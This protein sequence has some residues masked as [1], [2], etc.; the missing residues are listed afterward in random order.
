MANSSA[1]AELLLDPEVSDDSQHSLVDLL[2]GLGFLVECRRKRSHRSPDGLTWLVLA[3]L[4]L[5]AF[6]SGL[7]EQVA[8]DLY[9]KLEKLVRR[10]PAERDSS[11]AD[12]QVPL[13]LQDSE[14]DLRIVLEADLPAEAYRQLVGL[15]LNAYRVGPLHYDRS[16]GEWRSELDEAAG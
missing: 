3:A 4:P 13:V 12:N 8:D 11:S 1:D 10:R 5:Q 9:A 16:R 7:G 14:T 15:D 2:S 6:L